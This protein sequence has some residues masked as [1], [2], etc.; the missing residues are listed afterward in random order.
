MSPRH[1]FTPKIRTISQAVEIEYRYEANAFKTDAGKC[2][3]GQGSAVT[4]RR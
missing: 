3:G 1:D 4:Q 2:L